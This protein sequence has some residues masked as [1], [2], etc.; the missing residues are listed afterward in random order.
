MA[1]D[2]PYKTGLCKATSSALTSA[3]SPI[4]QIWHSISAMIANVLIVFHNCSIAFLL[5][6][7]TSFR[8]CRAMSWKRSTGK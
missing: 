7:N 1:T 2:G 3:D 8:L 6:V 5:E 4:S